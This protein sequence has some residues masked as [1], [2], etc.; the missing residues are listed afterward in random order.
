MTN[1]LPFTNE[2]FGLFQKLL[3]EESGLYFDAHRSK[4]LYSVLWE[5]LQKR[6]YDS[7]QE[8]YNFLKFHPE[9]QLEISKLL[10]LITIGET[11]FFRNSHHIETLK[12]YVLPEIFQRKA[13]SV[14]KSI[15][16]WSAGCSRGDE[17]YTIAILIMEAIPEYKNWEISILGTDVNRDA[18]IDA[19]EAVYSDS[20]IRSLP[21]G[22]IGKYFDKKGTNYILNDDVKSLVSF[23]YHNLARDP[24]TQ[25]RM[26]NL[27]TI[28]CRNVTIYFDLDTTKRVIDNFYNSLSQNGYLFIGHSETLWQIND[29][30]ETVEFPNTFVYKKVPYNIKEDSRRP[31]IGLPEINFE[32]IPSL[33]GLVL[34]KEDFLQKEGEAKDEEVLPEVIKERTCADI[35]L[36]PLYVESIK[37]FVQKKYEEALGLIDKILDQNREHVHAHF[38]KATILANQAKYNEAAGVLKK[39]IEVDNLYIEAYYLLGV[40]S[41]RTGDLKEAERQFRKVLYCDPKVTLAYFNLGNIYSYQRQFNRAIK[42]YNNVLKLLEKRSEQE[43]IRLCEDFTVESLSLACRSNLL[44]IEKKKAKI[45]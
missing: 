25:E 22:Y 29:K 44:E 13:Y 8:Y 24:F 28:F 14:D 34:E 43:Q 11:Y 32:D 5:R 36:N 31:F 21:Q 9:R 19:K 40:L 12:N 27:D 37:L 23:E 39:I 4:Y 10:S 42:E 20:H 45:K 17:P 2:I 30:F 18:L 35:N 16:I 38:T 6:G 1:A 7:Y 41:Y 15:R 26:L 3:L 33:Q